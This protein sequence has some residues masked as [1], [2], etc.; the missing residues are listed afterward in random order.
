MIETMKKEKI[1]E[2]VWIIDDF[3]TEEECA[4]HI[5]ASETIGYEFAKVNINGVQTVMPGVRDNQRVLMLDEYLA[6]EIWERLSPHIDTY[7]IGRPIGLNEMWRYY[8]YVPGER[9]KMHR[10]GSHQRNKTERSLLTLIVY[11]NDDFEGGETGFMVGMEVKPKKGRALIFEH[12]IRH[13]GKALTA[14]TKYVLR[15]DIMYE[16]KD[17][18]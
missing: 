12:K 9:F 3:L 5:K 8:K 7:P 6:A 18:L 2:E 16:L 13:E 11:L 15:T 10:D 14:G 1:A 4:F 17:S